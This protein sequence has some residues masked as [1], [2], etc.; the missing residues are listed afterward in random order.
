LDCAWKTGR[1][2]NTTTPSSTWL[3]DW[4]ATLVFLRSARFVLCLSERTLLPVVLPARELATLGTRLASAAGQVMAA[5]G[6][7]AEVARDEQ[8]R[9][10]EAV[11]ARTASRRVLGSMNDFA[12]MLA[13]QF[14][15]NASLLDLSLDLAET[16]CGPLR[17]ESPM[18]ATLER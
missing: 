12:F 8:D 4:Y 9:M 1:R 2:P 13:A 11:V 3:G 6:V 17:M 16:P 5:I 14:D 15:P 18:R 10:A 7:P